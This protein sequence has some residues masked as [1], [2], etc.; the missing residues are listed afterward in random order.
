[1]DKIFDYNG[2]PVT[3]SHEENIMVNATQ[4]A[5]P[6]GKT[7]KDW[8]RTEASKEFINSLS[9]VRQICLSE[10][11]KVVQG[12][13]PQ[14]QGT[15]MHEDVALEFARWLSPAFSIWCNDRIK[16][17]LQVGFTAT[18]MT[19]D[20]LVDNPDLIIKMATQLKR[21]QAENESKTAKIEADA[22]MVELANAITASTSSCLIG[23]LAKILTQNGYEIGQNRLFK[24][25]R[26]EGYLGKYGEYHNI[27]QQKYVEMGLFQIKKGTHT[28]PNG[29]L[30]TVT[31]T[32]VTGKGLQYFINKFLTKR[33]KKKR[34]KANRKIMKI[35]LLSEG[36]KVPTRADSGAAGFDLCAPKDTIINPGRNL[37][38]LDIVIE[39]NPGTEA[40][41]RPRSGFSLKGMEGYFTDGSD[42]PARFNADILL[43]TLDESY[44]GNVGVIIKSDETVPFI[45]KKGTRIAQMVISQYCSG[46]FDVVEELS[47]TKRG[48]GGFG[49]TG[50]K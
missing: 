38:P 7:A 50:T 29:E 42:A 27:P 30:H 39:L 17:L 34:P 44:R 9:T 3:F 13:T 19:I 31:T 28:G 32:K 22:P 45:I 18:P 26:N 15:W 21:L 46:T 33:K 48:E 2:C 6:F 4:M 16:E 1:M 14:E 43:G 8:L 10:L 37:L 40:Q 24:I 35:K 5:K 23:E 11:V 41:I 12:G 20:A 36:A 25:L 47:A 49:H